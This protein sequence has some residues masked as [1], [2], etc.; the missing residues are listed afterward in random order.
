MSCAVA[1]DTGSRSGG[2]TLKS[3][4][5]RFLTKVDSPAN[6]VVKIHAAD[7]TNSSNPASDSL[8]T[9]TG[10]NPDTAGLYTYTCP[11]ND[12]GCNLSKDKTYFVVTST[13]DASGQK[14]Y[15]LAVTNS[16]DEAVH[17]TGTAGWSIA[18]AARAKWGSAAWTNLTGAPTGLLHVA[19]D[20]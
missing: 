10:S 12:T 19:L 1:F 18:N 11:A 5:G 17:P 15:D 8:V 4:T 3:V 9:L 13:S 6:I 2:Y 16:D 20:D 14:N 7:T